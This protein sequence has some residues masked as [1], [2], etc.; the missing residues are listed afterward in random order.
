MVLSVSGPLQE[1]MCPPAIFP[2]KH[3]TS[4][5]THSNQWAGAVV[6]PFHS[7]SCRNPG[8]YCRS[9]LVGLQLQIPLFL[10]HPMQGVQVGA[11]VVCMFCK[12]FAKAVVFVVR[13]ASL[14]TSLQHV[15]GIH[16]Q[17]IYLQFG[18]PP[19]A[20]GVPPHAPPYMDISGSRFSRKECVHQLFSRQST[21]FPQT[22][23]ATRGPG[24]WYPH[25]IAVSA[26]TRASIA[27][28]SSLVCNCKSHSSFASLRRVSKS[29]HQL[30]ACFSN[31]FQKLR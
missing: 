24:L 11:P 13:P 25:S 3:H 8:K 7:C 1:R 28:R 14:E 21:R 5:N 2:A 30:S 26:G 22:H 10:R 16:T 18:A 31:S 23:T 19:F 4:T 6:S 27:G 9:Q 15:A 20:F 17:G 12:L 29:V